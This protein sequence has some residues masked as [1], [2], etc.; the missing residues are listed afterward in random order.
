MASVLFV[1]PVLTGLAMACATHLAQA[2]AQAQAQARPTDAQVITVTGKSRNNTVTVA[3]FGDLPLSAAPFS[4]TV[5]SNSQLQDA[6]INGLA[7]LTRLDAGITDAYNPPGYWSQLAVRGFTL[8]NRFNYW[9][10]GLPINAETV[11]P[12]ANKQ[13]LE[14]LKG[15]SGLQAGTSAPGGLVNLVVKRPTRQVRAATLTFEEPGS[16][17]VSIDVGDRV[18][19]RAGADDS[20]GWRINASADRLSSSVRNSQGSRSVLAGAV[21]ARLATGSLLEAEFE[22]SHQSQPSVPGFSLLGSRLPAAST[23]DPRINLNNQ[24]WSLP[25]VFDGRTA[26]L[27]FTQALTEGVNFIAHAMSQQLR[28]DDRIAFPSGCSAEDDYTRYCSDGS[29]DLYDFRSEGERRNSRALD[30]SIAGQATWA[31]WTH[32]FNVGVL[33]SSFNSR[34]GRQAYNYVGSGTIDGFAR[35]APDASLTDDN[36]QRDE[37][38]TELHLQ[39]MLSLTPH[40]RLFAGLRH[41]RVQRDSVRTD[42]SRATAYAQSF[43]TPWLALSQAVGDNATAY[44]NWGQG[45]ESEVA[46]NRSRYTNAGQ[47]LPALKSQQVE[48]GFKHST[49]V[50]DWRTALFTI[51]RPEWRDIGMCSTAGSCTR[52]ADGRSRHSGI[53]AEA[54]WR[55]GTISLR[56]SALLLRARREGSDDASLNGQRPTNVPAASLK[57]QAAYNVAAL[58]GLAVLGFVTH[59]GQ[60]MVLPDNSVATPGWTRLDLAARYSQKLGEHSSA[61]WRLG[62]DNISNQRAWKEAPYQY[63][64]AYLYPL[65]PR[66]IHASLAVAY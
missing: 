23:M 54:E 47:A 26:S 51:T 30:V 7:D 6:G 20:V 63:G 62:V 65:A 18:G 16:I 45:I 55:A 15:I 41:S 8:D 61:V 49:T 58:P 13:A 34:F 33:S 10:D 12:Q 60:R 14:I 4:A 52:R 36:T 5:I 59:E 48:V 24:A 50:L 27:R 64:H 56:G 1:R 35:V 2:Q 29:F 32:R 31:G 46:P 42:G 39:D 37:R 21:D 38:S 28:T 22:V 17:G 19:D 53:E 66:A 57:L 40:T 44:A 43:T 3:G 25:V 11:I 9:R